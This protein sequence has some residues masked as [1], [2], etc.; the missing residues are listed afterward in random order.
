MS[1]TRV[2]QVH[3]A[4]NRAVKQVIARFARGN[5]SAQ[6]QRVLLPDEQDAERRASVPI[7]RKWKA[8][9]KSAAP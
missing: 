2:A 8:R 4:W 5:I 9:Y 6:E 7:A 3:S 1:W